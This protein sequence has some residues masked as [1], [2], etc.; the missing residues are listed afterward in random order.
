[1]ANANAIVRGTI[2]QYLADV[3]V[4]YTANTKTPTSA[5]RLLQISFDI[6]VVDQVTGKMLW[7]RKTSWLKDSMKNN[8]KHRGVR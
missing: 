3:P 6:D 8:T 1:V 7:S 4:G 2:R 5:R